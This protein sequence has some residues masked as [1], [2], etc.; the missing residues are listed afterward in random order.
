M[1]SSEDVV[2]KKCG[3]M[4]QAMY[5]NVGRVNTELIMSRAFRSFYQ[6]LG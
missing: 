3:D 6:V 2:R 4:A 5:T 1:Q